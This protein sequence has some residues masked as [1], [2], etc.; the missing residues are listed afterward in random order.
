[1]ATEVT[2]SG[3]GRRRALIAAFFFLG[4]ALYCAIDPFKKGPMVDFPG[5]ET[6]LVDLPPWSALPPER[7]MESRLQKAEQ[8]FLGQVQGP[9]SVAFDLSGRG[10]YTGVADGRV[11]FWDGKGWSGFAYTSPNR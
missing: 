5:F 11:V 9:E 4:L 7:D 3:G 2:V 6:Y 10:P 1:M 8:R